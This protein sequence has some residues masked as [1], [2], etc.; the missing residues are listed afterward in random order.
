MSFLSEDAKTTAGVVLAVAAA[1]G[2]LTLVTSDQSVTLNERSAIFWCAALAL[3][4]QWLVWLPASLLQ[5][6]RF[7]DLTG[8]LTYLAVTAFSLWAGSTFAAPSAR[9]WIVSALVAVWAVRL[10]CFLFLRIHRAGK[11]GRFD[12]LKT[13]PVRFLVPWTLQALWVFVTLNVVIVLNCKYVPS[14]PLGLW[15]AVGIGMWVLGFGIEVIADHQKTAFNARPENHGKWIDEGL[16]AR[17]RHPNYFGE[18]LLWAG[19]AVIG[20]HSLDDWEQA[21]LVSPVFVHLL[22]T[23]IS[24]IPLLDKRAMAKW[25]QDPEYQACLLYTSPSPRDGLLSRMPSSA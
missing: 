13:S 25:G 17:S 10:S 16:W 15:D 9:E 21:A 24:G 6:E 1:M 5:S 20:Y 4:V 23:K 19:I 14:S 11:D 18:I 8:G 22:L 2:F 3:G 7:F 12:D